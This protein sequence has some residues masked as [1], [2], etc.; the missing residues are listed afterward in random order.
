MNKKVT[1]TE[2]INN[3]NFL[4]SPETSVKNDEFEEKKKLSDVIII[5]V[6]FSDY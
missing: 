3:V 6:C 2:L 4:K 5:V 1:I